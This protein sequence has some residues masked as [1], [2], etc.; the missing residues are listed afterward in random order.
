[1]PPPMNGYQLHMPP[2]VNGYQPQM[3][4]YHEVLKLMREFGMETYSGGTDFLKADRWRK[5][6][7]RNFALI[8]CPVGYKVELAVQYLRDKAYE[9]WEGVIIGMPKGDVMQ[10]E[11]FTHEFNRKYFLQEAEDRL[12]LDFL[13]LEH[14]NQTVKNYAQQFN[15][16]KRFSGRD[17][18]ERRLV[19]KF[20]KR[21]RVDIR[22]RYQLVYY[23][24]VIDLVEKAALMEKG[25]EDEAK[26]VRGTQFRVTRQVD[27][28]RHFQDN[29]GAIQGVVRLPV[30]GRCGR[31]HTGPCGGDNRICFGCGQIGHRKPSCPHAKTACTQCGRLGHLAKDCRIRTAG[32]QQGNQNRDQLAPPPKRSALAPRVFVAEVEDPTGDVYG[33]EYEY[34]TV[35][36]EDAEP[37][38]GE[39]VKKVRRV[40]TAGLKAIISERTFKDVPV[41]I[42]GIELLADLIETPLNRYEIIFGMT[43]LKRHRAVLDCRRAKVSFTR[44]EGKLVYQGMKKQSGVPIFSMIKTE[45]L[46]SKGCEAFLATISVEKGEA[47]ITLEDIPLKHCPETHDSHL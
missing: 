40:E 41:I 6:L 19:K 18:S 46:I 44:A 29:R 38:A 42:E 25:I 31:A 23:A 11:D 20:M 3:P 33:E 17:V 10:W 2:A 34:V 5:L 37:I 13:K 45:E 9:W 35:D 36:D 21:L 7:Q 43:W 32:Q 27:T 26:M 8:R 47:E 24:S 16:L 22:N 12:A 30:C 14:G 28:Q 39:F 1:M 15:R 4:T